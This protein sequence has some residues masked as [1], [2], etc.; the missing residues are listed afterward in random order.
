MPSD[1]GYGGRNEYCEAYFIRGIEAQVHQARLLCEG[2]IREGMDG[3]EN[4]TETLPEAS[5]LEF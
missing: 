1:A 3:C 2:N 4:D 5:S